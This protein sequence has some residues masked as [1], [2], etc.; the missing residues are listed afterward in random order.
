MRSA[1]G[2]PVR[3]GGDPRVESFFSINEGATALPS[4]EDATEEASPG[5][6]SENCLTPPVAVPAEAPTEL[7]ESGPMSEPP[8]ASLPGFSSP[9]ED[10]APVVRGGGFCKAPSGSSVR[11][12]SSF[13]EDSLWAIPGRSGEGARTAPSFSDET[14]R[15]WQPTKM[16]KTP[17]AQNLRSLTLRAVAHRVVAGGIVPDPLWMEPRKILQKCGKRQSSVA[18]VAGKTRI[19]RGGLEA[20]RKVWE[21]RDPVLESLIVACLCIRQVVIWLSSLASFPEAV[22]L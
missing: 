22:P 6:P 11:S 4:S 16:H 15:C 2:G 9:W 12:G 8:A 13:G 7:F 21:R 20:Q 14:D 3:P 5:G 19:V 18:P 17:A 10:G 1:G